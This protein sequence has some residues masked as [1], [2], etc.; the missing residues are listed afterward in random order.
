MSAEIN[1]SDGK[2]EQLSRKAPAKRVTYRDAQYPGLVFVIETSGTATFAWYRKVMG[3]PTWK[4]IGRHP[5]CSLDYARSEA[6]GYNQNL[7][8][9][10]D[11]FTSANGATLRDA[12]DRYCDD[13]LSEH[14]KKPDKAVKDARWQFDKYLSAWH[15]RKLDTIKDSDVASLQSKLRKKPGLH[16]ANRTLQLLRAVINF[17]ISKRIFAPE[18]GQNPVSG[19]TLYK[20][21]KRDRFIQPDEMAAVWSQLDQE[22]NLD[23]RDFVVLALTTG[24]RKS[25]V[26]SMRWKDVCKTATGE[27]FWKITDPKNDEPYNVPLLPEAWQ[28]LASRKL[29]YGVKSAWVFPRAKDPKKH[30]LDLKKSFDRFRKKV[31]CADLRVHD[32]R[33]TLGSW[34]AAQ[35]TSLQIIG[36]GL[37]H[38]SSA[39]TEIYARL[40]LDPV[41]ASME[42]ATRAMHAARALPENSSA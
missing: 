26:L 37:G 30:V 41:R 34:Q 5:E 2:L 16:T 22:G 32:L 1:F 14:S 6:S 20:E 35:G 29:K 9:G 42:S 8:K 23:L 15:E 4:K 40:N 33:R 18:A 31:G 10:D 11:P 13:H 36:K 7:L 24:A 17:A 21:K 12:F 38:K 25:D 3:R 28:V 19:L 39:A 27:Q